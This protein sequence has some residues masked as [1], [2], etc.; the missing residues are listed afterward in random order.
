[1]QQEFENIFITNSTKIQNLEDKACTLEKKLEKVELQSGDQA[2]TELQD[3]II[4]GGN[5]LPSVSVNEKC[6]QVATEVI[7]TKLSISLPNNVIVAAY[8]L[9]KKDNKQAR[10]KRK[11]LV[12]FTNKQQKIYL[13]SASK[14]A[15]PDDLFVLENLTPLRQK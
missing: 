8:G 15:K 7:R 14:T 2:A 13:I 1:M 6:N 5:A 10:D 3:T 4:L 11:I 9:G 12:R